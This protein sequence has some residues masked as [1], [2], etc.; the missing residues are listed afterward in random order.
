M[1]VAEVCEKLD[2]LDLKNR[3]WLIQGTSA[4]TG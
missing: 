2:L 1:S 3:H 4:I